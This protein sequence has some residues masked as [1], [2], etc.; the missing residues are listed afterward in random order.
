MTAT[1]TNRGQLTIP[2]AVRRKMGLRA[3][4]RVRFEVFSEP[5]PSKQYSEMPEPTLPVSALKGLFPK[6]ARAVTIQEMNEAIGCGGEEKANGR[7]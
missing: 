2:A 4:S 3:G 1:V 6:P 7:T 5:K